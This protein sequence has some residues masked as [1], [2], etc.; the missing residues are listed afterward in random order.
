MIVA[1]PRGV[2]AWRLGFDIVGWGEGTAGELLELGD[3]DEPIAGRAGRWMGRRRWTDFV[4]SGGDS[5][6]SSDSGGS[7]GYPMQWWWGG[8]AVVVEVLLLCQGGCWLLLTERAF[9]ALEVGH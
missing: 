1:N 8:V 6:D 3:I 7:S 9:P 2:T 5:G 4:A